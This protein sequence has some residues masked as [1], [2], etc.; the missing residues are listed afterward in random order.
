[1]RAGHPLRCR[2][3]FPELL[4]GQVAS[5]ETIDG[6]LP[7]L[8]PPAL[9]LPEGARAQAKPL[10][11]IRGIAAVYRTV[12][13]CDFWGIRQNDGLFTAQEVVLFIR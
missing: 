1:M 6:V 7:T 4:N 13:N 11:P 2:R 9:L 8:H 10:D 5:G 3:E 12:R